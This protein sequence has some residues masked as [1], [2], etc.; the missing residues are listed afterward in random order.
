MRLGITRPAI[1]RLRAGDGYGDRMYL[2]IG[3]HFWLA[4]VGLIAPAPD[5]LGNEHALVDNH[6]RLLADQA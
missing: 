4:A 6:G 3:W 1:K 2:A 5:R